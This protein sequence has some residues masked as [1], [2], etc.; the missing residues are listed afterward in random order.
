MRILITMTTILALTYTVIA[1]DIVVTT[2][3]PSVVQVGQQFRVTWTVNSR[4]GSLEAPDFK[5]FYK[6]MGPQSSFS[7]S[8]SIVNGKVTSTI[9]NSFIYYLQA[10]KEGKFTLDRAKYILKNKEYFSTP[11]TIEVVAAD[12]QQDT[13]GNQLPGNEQ[14]NIQNEVAGNDLYVRLLVNRNK[15]VIGEHIV[16]TLKIYSRV[17]L[18][19]LQEVTFPDFNGFLK[20]DLETPPLRTLEKEN[21]GGKIYDTGVIQRFL[22]YPQKTGTLEIDPSTLTVLIQQRVK[23]NDPFFGDFFSS[24]NNMPKVIATLPVKIE[25]QPLP[26]GAPESFS[27]T[28]GSISISSSADMDT[29]M[30]NDALNYKIRLEGKGNLK[31]AA[32]PELTLSPDIEVYEPKIVNNLKTSTSGTSGSKTFEYVLIPRHHGKYTIPSIKY[33]YFDSGSRTYRTVSTTE[34]TFFVRKGDVDESTGQLIGG[35]AGEDVTYLGKDIRYIDTGKSRLKKKSSIIITRSSFFIIY[36]SSLLIFILVIVIRKEH[37]KRNADIMRV[38]NRNAPKVARSRL[39]RAHDHLKN[40]A[41]QEFYAELLKALWGYLS[42]KMGIPVSDISMPIVEER[43]DNLGVEPDTVSTLRNTIEICEFSRYA[44]DSSR[45]SSRELYNNA[46]AI[47][48]TIENAM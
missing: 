33:S 32:A 9:K 12:Q 2:D 20:T 34:H 31:L 13:E 24:Y 4:N 47:I 42:D 37:L 6:L 15:V 30:V 45:E 48:K 44:P 29:M 10:T 18:S 46:V 43:L 5:D 36:I 11:K 19:G 1:Q 41:D 17:N 21:V 35:F 40:A 23:S 14:E 16:A 7:Q 25:V 22:I 38:K 8:T 26:Q 27:G 28:V 3:A 39:K